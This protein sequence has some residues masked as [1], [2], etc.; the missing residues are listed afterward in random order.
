MLVLSL[1]PLCSTLVFSLISHFSR[2][3]SKKRPNRNT[4]FQSR[5]AVEFGLQIC[6]RD[7]GASS[8]VVKTVC[9]FCKVFGKEEAVVERKCRHSDCV[10]YFKAPFWKENFSSH[11]KRMHSSKWTKYC[12]L[13]SGANNSFFDIGSSSGSQ[14]TIH[15][16]SGPHTLPFRA[17]I[18]K[19]I[20]DIIIGNMIFHP[21]DMVGITRARLIA[22]FVPTLDSSE[23]AVESGNISQYAIIVNNTNQFQLVAQ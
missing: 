5:H 22:S 21:V 15:V 4:P 16:F 3:M 19:D 20:V 12:E 18:D 1:I 17:L 2:R 10:K 6:E 14:A 9:R 11:N 23:D 7:A 8:T 13:D